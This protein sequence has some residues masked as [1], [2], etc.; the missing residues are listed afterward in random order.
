MQ[1]HN[2]FVH[3]KVQWQLMAVSSFFRV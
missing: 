1:F 3:E 2:Y